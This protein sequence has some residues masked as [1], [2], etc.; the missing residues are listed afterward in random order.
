MFKKFLIH[1]V[2]KSIPV[3]FA[4]SLSVSVLPLASMIED[5]MS[6]VSSLR[7]PINPLHF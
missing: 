2:S 7:Y 6:I 5:R 1:F 4:A 3:F